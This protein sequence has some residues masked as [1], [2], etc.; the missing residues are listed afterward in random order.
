[1]QVLGF[2]VLLEGA[3]GS[4]K[5]EIA[6]ELIAR[7]HRFVADDVVRIAVHP[8]GVLVGRAQSN[9]D[10]WMEIRGVGLLSVP[11]LYG[12]DAVLS[13]AAIDFV[14][15]IECWDD[16]LPHPRISER[17]MVEHFG[18]ILPMYRLPQPRIATPAVLIE[19][20]ARQHRLATQRAVD[21]KKNS[22]EHDRNA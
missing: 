21:E 14:C 7:G 10:G 15:Q 18:V 2:G 5:S 1:M 8:S 22:S 17:E 12:A 13:A 4:G 11:D 9:I 16:F 3:S 20:M 6:L 19:L